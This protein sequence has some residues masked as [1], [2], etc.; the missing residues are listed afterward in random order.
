MEVLDRA[1]SLSLKNQ[2]WN[3]SPKEVQKICE[4]LSLILEH[5]GQGKNIQPYLPSII[6]NCLV[7]GAVRQIRKL[8]YLVIKFAGT[9]YELPWS[10]VSSAVSQDLSTPLDPE[11]QI[12]ALR[13]LY[14]LP[15]EETISIFSGQEAFIISAVK[16]QNGEAAQ[17][18]FLISLPG[19]M[20]RIWCGLGHESLQLQDA[21]REIFKYILGFTLDS[22]DQLCCLAFEALGYL[23]QECEDGR[24]RGLSQELEANGSDSE[25]LMPLVKYLCAGL[26]NNLPMVMYRAN[27]ID[28]RQRIKILYPLTKLV[29]MSGSPQELRRLENECLSPTLYNLEKCIIWEVSRCLVLLKPETST[30]WAMCSQLLEQSTSELNPTPLLVLVTA[31]L[32]QLPTSLQLSIS[33]ETLRHSNRIPSQVDRF[34]VL[35]SCLSSVVNLSE[36]LLQS[37][38][39]SAIYQLFSQTWFVE[40]WMHGSHNSSREE[41]LCCLIESCLNIH[42]ISEPWLTVGLEVVDVCFKVLEWPCSQKNTVCSN[43][44]FLLLEEVCAAAKMCAGLNDRIQQTLENLLSRF[45]AGNVGIPHQYSSYFAIL[46]CAKYW[47]PRTEEA[48]EKFVDML[49]IRLFSTELIG[50][51]SGIY[52]QCTQFLLCSCMH[53][54]RRFAVQTA[55]VMHTTLGEFLEVSEKSDKDQESISKIISYV[56][57]YAEH[58]GN[59]EFSPDLAMM[60]ERVH[61]KIE[62]E[63]E[64]YYDCMHAA[65]NIFKIRRN[66]SFQ[67]SRPMELLRIAQPQKEL[68]WRCLPLTE[69]TGIC[70]P[71]RAFCTHVIYPQ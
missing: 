38:E 65:L 5:L 52:K 60:L 61:C 28:F 50:I 32:S 36:L 43:Y 26:L 18:G 35:L 11:F 40:M 46:I 33:L 22:D 51:D 2:S 4:S 44:F 31:G 17:L 68:N 71:L 8:A 13:L 27:A 21:I 20:I 48:L 30:L 29:C 55:K 59:A 66:E 63:Y 37:N 15:L 19:L 56:E 24:L 47:L 62:E 69:I 25:M 9:L 10:G 42:K 3:Q 41:L 7:P 67:S 45:D 53:L 14:I 49:R 12:Y 16:G 70:D 39:P 57:S 34:S 54:A 1:L 58:E 64:Y 6:D 23:F